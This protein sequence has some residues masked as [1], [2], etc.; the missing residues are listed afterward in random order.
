M[1]K[2]SYVIKELDGTT[3]SRCGHEAQ[4]RQ[5]THLSEKVLKQRFY[6]RV[7]YNCPNPNCKTTIFMLEYWKVWNDNEAAKNLKLLQEDFENRENIS[8]LF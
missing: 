6:Y 7:W 2:K 3:C 4:T 1:K 8:R 5:H